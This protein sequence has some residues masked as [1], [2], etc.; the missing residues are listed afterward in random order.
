MANR[1]NTYT[2]HSRGSYY[3]DLAEAS[4]LAIWHIDDGL[5]SGSDDL[6]FENNNNEKHKLVDLE[7][8]DGLFFDRWAP[9]AN[10]TNNRDPVSGGDNL[11]YWTNNILLSCYPI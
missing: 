1:Q 9:S 5:S 7:C 2:E 4:G 6:R 11:D 3:D 8:A 10:P